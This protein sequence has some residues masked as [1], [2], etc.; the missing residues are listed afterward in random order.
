MPERYGPYNT[1]YSRFRS[2]TKAGL[3]DRI[4]DAIKDAYGGAVRMIECTSVRVHHAAA[5]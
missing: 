4:I 1:R 5:I 3:W 2:W